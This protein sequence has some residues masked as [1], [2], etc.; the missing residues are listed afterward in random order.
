MHTTINLPRY[1]YTVQCTHPSGKLGCWIFAGDDH[2]T[3]EPISPLFSDLY[4]LY[5][6]MNANGWESV[7]AG[8]WEARRVTP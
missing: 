3:G 5:Q 6:W 2:K 7:P 4:N 1:G 8:I